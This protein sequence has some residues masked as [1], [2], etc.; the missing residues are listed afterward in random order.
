VLEKKKQV[1]KREKE[2]RSKQ[3]FIIGYR[4]EQGE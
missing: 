1:N 3:G 2:E 4:G